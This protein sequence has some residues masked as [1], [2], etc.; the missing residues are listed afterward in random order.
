MLMSLQRAKVFRCLFS[1]RDAAPLALMGDRKDFPERFP[2][3]EGGENLFFPLPQDA[4]AEKDAARLQEISGDPAEEDNDR[5]QD[6]GKDDVKA[7]KSELLPKL[8][9]LRAD[10]ISDAKAEAVP[11]ETVCEEVFSHGLC[12]R[13]IQVRGV[14]RCRA[15]LQRGDPE[16]AGAG[17]D[18]QNPH[19]G[20]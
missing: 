12:R 14:D 16:D 6:I 9:P 17:P 11:G 8:L 15:E 4:G 5:R 2:L 18:I 1:D 3:P 13:L 20:L 19:T 7:G 10:D